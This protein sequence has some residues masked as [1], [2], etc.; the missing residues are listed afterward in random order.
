M[1]EP[2]TA[3]AGCFFSLL[4]VRQLYFGCVPHTR[5]SSCFAAVELRGEKVDRGGSTVGI[6]IACQCGGGSLVG[7]LAGCTGRAGNL[8][9]EEAGSEQE[10]AEAGTHHQSN[11]LRSLAFALGR[12]H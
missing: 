10:Q 7:R 12:P 3:M 11:P 2:G 1:V 8:Q 9:A 5:I 6:G 4:C